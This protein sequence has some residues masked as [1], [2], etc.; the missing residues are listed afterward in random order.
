MTVAALVSGIAAR[1]K[2]TRSGP[3]NSAGTLDVTDT[4][5]ARRRQAS[6]DDRR[7]P[8]A[9]LLP[10][11]RRRRRRQPGWQGGAC[12]GVRCIGWRGAGIRTARR[13][14]A[15]HSV[16]FQSHLLHSV[17]ARAP[18]R[19]SSSA[20]VS[21][22][23]NQS[24]TATDTNAAPNALRSHSGAWFMSAVKRLS[25]TTR[26]PPAPRVT[27]AAADLSVAGSRHGTNTNSCATKTTILY[28]LRSHGT[29]ASCSA[30]NRP[31]LNVTGH[32]RFVTD[33]SQ[34]D[35]QKTFFVV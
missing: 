16:C 23:V 32:P 30:L 13:Q 17:T 33:T 22:F 2:Y 26:S 19:R 7:R 24:K 28:I 4:G 20:V 25:H 14:P 21:F 12:W 11:N 1:P 35:T 31:W 6:N 5:N 18:S 3:Y 9:S 10:S 29:A 8:P 34:N 27:N 15:L